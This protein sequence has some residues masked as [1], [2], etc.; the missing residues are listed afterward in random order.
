MLNPVVK[1]FLSSSA[2][3]PVW[4]KAK[5]QPQENGEA[6]FMQRVTDCTAWRNTFDRAMPCYRVY[7]RVRA[8]LDPCTITDGKAVAPNGKRR[9]VL[10]LGYDGMRADM[11]PSLLEG[12]NAYDPALPGHRGGL[13][14]LADSDGGVYLAYCG[15]ETGEPTQQ[16]TSTSAGW[17]AQF[18]GTWGTENGI[19]DNTDT[20]NMQRETFL[21]HYAKQGLACALAFDW[22]PFFNLNLKPEVEYAMAH[23]EL[24]LQYRNLSLLTPED[25]QDQSDC[26]PEFAAF[27]AP[28]QVVGFAPGDSAVR[29]YVCSRIAA[30]DDI[31]CGIYDAIDGAGH[32]HGF[33]PTCS[34]YAHAAAVCDDYTGRVLDV[35]EQRQQTENEE[36]LV[37]LANDHGGK[38][39]GHGGQSLQERTTWIA[40]NRA[41]DPALWG[42]N[43]DGNR[44]WGAEKATIHGKD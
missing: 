41:I 42:Y 6:L 4:I 34:A 39:K 7:D 24:R 13:A 25:G 30:G 26:T 10:F 16:S 44:A 1:Q 33:L 14:R 2:V 23:R 32:G 40:C 22:A 11:V 5:I 31:I 37:L 8:F 17:T 36:W 28:E 35:I 12:K 3:V 27:T 38:G 9:R 18:T 19:K 21:L 29:D 43:Y 15:G 20:K